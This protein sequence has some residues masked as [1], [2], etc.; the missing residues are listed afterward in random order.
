MLLSLAPLRAN[1]MTLDY[2][3]YNWRYRPSP[4]AGAKPVVVSEI[5]VC[6][7]C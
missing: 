6:S 5:D 3:V 1:G 2:D 4:V 7:M